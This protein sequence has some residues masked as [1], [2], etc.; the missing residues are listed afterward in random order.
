MLTGIYSSVDTQAWV[1]LHSQTMS[2]QG[3]P[4]CV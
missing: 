2:Q 3:N 1:N 4:F